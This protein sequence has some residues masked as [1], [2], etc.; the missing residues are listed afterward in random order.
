[1][2]V[3][4]KVI[5]EMCAAL[6]EAGGVDL[7]TPTVEE[8]MRAAAA[9]LERHVLERAIE[10][11]L[12][13]GPG[14]GVRRDRDAVYRDGFGTA[15]AS[16]IAAIRALIPPPATGTPTPLPPCPKAC[17]ADGC[18]LPALSGGDACVIHDGPDPHD[19]G[20]VR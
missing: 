10:S 5:R 17:A 14:P 2:P 15:A 13:L 7:V 9:V 6:W 8:A 19:G 3:D 18:D 12:G 11:V 16:A 4:D 1:M 20:G